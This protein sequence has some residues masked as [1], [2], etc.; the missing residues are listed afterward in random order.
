MEENT[1]QTAKI[2]T[3]GGSQAV[4]LPKDCRLDTDEVMVTKIGS[5]VMLVPRNKNNRWV[6]MLTALDMF[7]D[8]FLSEEIEALPLNDPTVI[9]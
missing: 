1:M 4:R 5:I 9:L 6:N 3:N 8:D 7:T 2:F